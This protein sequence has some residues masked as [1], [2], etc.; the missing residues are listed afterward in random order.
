MPGDVVFSDEP[1]RLADTVVPLAGH[2]SDECI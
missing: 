2:Q 1:T